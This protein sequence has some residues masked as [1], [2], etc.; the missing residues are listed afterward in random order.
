VA[1]R[2]WLGDTSFRAA[3][4]YPPGHW[5]SHGQDLVD[6]TSIEINHFEAPAGN[7]YCLSG[8]RQVAQMGENEA[9]ERLIFTPG[10]QGDT[11]LIRHFVGRHRSSEEPRAI[12][13][14]DGLWFPI[15]HI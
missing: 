6:A 12:V 4:D 11:Q 10:G 5:A 8:F 9:G 14:W 15:A 13:A 2:R 1:R 3:S 7:L